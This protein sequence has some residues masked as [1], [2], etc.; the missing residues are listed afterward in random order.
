MLVPRYYSILIYTVI[1]S[2]P[3]SLELAILLQAW[4]TNLCL[5]SIGKQDFLFSTMV[6]TTAKEQCYSLQHDYSL[7]VTQREQCWYHLSNRQG[8]I[9]VVCVNATR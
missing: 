4:L 1:Q 7:K 5:I 6:T 3:K 2:Q 8:P 9:G